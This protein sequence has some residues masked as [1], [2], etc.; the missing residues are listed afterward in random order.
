MAAGSKAKKGLASVGDKTS[1]HPACYPPTSLVLSKKNKK[2]FT[3]KKP[4]SVVGDLTAPHVGPKEDCSAKHADMINK[5]G[6]SKKVFIMKIP[7]AVQGQNLTPKAG[8]KPAHIIEGSKKH[9][10]MV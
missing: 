10:C 6:G 2:I 1:A 9:F 7:V 5:V 4:V 3:L 8:D